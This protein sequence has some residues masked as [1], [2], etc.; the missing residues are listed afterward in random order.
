M[1]G[2]EV[3]QIESLE[4]TNDLRDRELYGRPGARVAVSPA[5]LCAGL[6]A[7]FSAELYPGDHPFG[8]HVIYRIYVAMER[9]KL[10][11]TSADQASL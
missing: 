5:M 9:A 4:R 7:A 1:A 10:T 2:N 6:H 8:D 3:L 11:Y